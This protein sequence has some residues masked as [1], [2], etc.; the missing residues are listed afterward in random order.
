MRI[1]IAKR[2]TIGDIAQ[3]LPAVAVILDANA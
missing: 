3:T 1:L 2:G